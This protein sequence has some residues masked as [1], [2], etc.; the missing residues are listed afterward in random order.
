MRIVLHATP[1]FNPYCKLWPML[2]PICSLMSTH[3][4]L[5]YLYFLTA[6]ASELHPVS[7]S[8]L[9]CKGSY[10]CW[11]IAAQAGCV[12][13]YISVVARGLRYRS[14]DYEQK[15]ILTW[16]SN[17]RYR[18]E[19]QRLWSPVLLVLS[20]VCGNDVNTSKTK[21][22]N[23][24]FICNLTNVIP[25]LPFLFNMANAVPSTDV[26]VNSETSD[27]V[28]SFNFALCAFASKCFPME[29]VP[30]SDEGRRTWWQKKHMIPGLPVSSLPQYK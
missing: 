21:M 8:S 20:I 7:V 1:N 17:S 24:H 11:R 25:K 14:E 16:G 13:H 10:G 27:S 29:L 22:S 6:I 28:C 18:G 23:M 2:L 12:M 5:S 26:L 4:K 30:C 19:I 3:L 15:Q 9:S